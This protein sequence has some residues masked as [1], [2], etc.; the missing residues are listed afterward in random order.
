M[1]GECSKFGGEKRCI[2]GLEKPEGKIPLGSS[3][4]RMGG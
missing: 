3:R 4:S 1:I 2:L